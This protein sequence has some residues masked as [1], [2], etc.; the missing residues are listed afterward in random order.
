MMTCQL[1]TCQVLHRRFNFTLQWFRHKSIFIVEF[2]ISL[3]RKRSRTCW[4]NHTRRNITAWRWTRLKWHQGVVNI[5]LNSLKQIVGS[6]QNTRDL[7][8]NISYKS[9]PT[10]FIT[11]Y[12]YVLN[13]HNVTPLQCVQQWTPSSRHW[14]FD[15]LPLT[16][17]TLYNTVNF[18][19]NTHKRHSIARPKGRGMGCLLWVQRGTYCVDLSKLSSIKYLL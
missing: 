4:N 14:N 5:S 7:I 2:W 17:E 6:N 11:F 13:V 1:L 10:N 8:N 16:V 19:W 15:G 18:C 12:E 9:Y 3:H